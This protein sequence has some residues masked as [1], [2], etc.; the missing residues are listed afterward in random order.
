MDRKYWPSWEKHD[1]IL[2]LHSECALWDR[3]RDGSCHGFASKDNLWWN[4]DSLS[5]L[6]WPFAS[7]TASLTYVSEPTNQ[8]NQISVTL[9]L[10]QPNSHDHLPNV[11]PSLLKNFF[12]I[13]IN[14]TKGCMA[15]ISFH[16]VSCSSGID[17]WRV[18]KT[19]YSSGLVYVTDRDS[20]CVFIVQSAHGKLHIILKVMG[21]ILYSVACCEL[22]R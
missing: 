9:A 22:I 7:V 6:A 2:G 14:A 15:F 16:S 17:R 12:S 21:C 13:N 10:N 4:S 19:F 8:T 5:N 20:C 1:N 18:L 3:F 11:I